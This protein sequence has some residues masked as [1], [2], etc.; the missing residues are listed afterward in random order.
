MAKAIYCLKMYIFRNQFDL[1][2]REEKSIAD[3][4]VFIVKLYV[5]VWFKAPLTSSA[6]LCKI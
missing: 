5:K 1:Q 6:P 3:I 2:H 4:C